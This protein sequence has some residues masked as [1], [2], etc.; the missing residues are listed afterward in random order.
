MQHPGP[1]SRNP[2][3]PPPSA[4][5][6]SPSPGP[7]SPQGSSMVGRHLHS[8]C[9]LLPLPLVVSF[10][11]ADQGLLCVAPEPSLLAG[12]KDQMGT[13][14]RWTRS[15]PGTAT[16]GAGEQ[17]RGCRPG[18]GR[19]ALG[20]EGRARVALQLPP[21]TWAPGAQTGTACHPRHLLIDLAEEGSHWSWPDWPGFSPSHPPLWP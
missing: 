5:P 4:C 15:A 21:P 18:A 9:S 1:P 14:T 3:P 7:P 8:A 20:W 17:T 16:Q 2:P 6:D 19:R 13:D 12:V 10:L 11:G